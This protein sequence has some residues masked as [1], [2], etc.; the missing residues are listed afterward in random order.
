MQCFVCFQARGSQDGPGGSRGPAEGHTSPKILKHWE[1]Y[2]SSSKTIQKGSLARKVSCRPFV[3][4]SADK[5]SPHGS[6]ETACLVTEA[7]VLLTDSVTAR[8]ALSLGWIVLHE[9]RNSL[10]RLSTAKYI[11]ALA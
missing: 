11:A 8:Q 4:N 5:K 7:P 2:E 6:F 9:I 10:V 3:R 1:T